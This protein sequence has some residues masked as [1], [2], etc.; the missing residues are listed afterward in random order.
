MTS[1]I[2]LGFSISAK[3]LLNEYSQKRGCKPYYS[4]SQK[5]YGFV[6]SVYIEG[7]LFEGAACS[8]KKV[9]EQYAAAEALKILAPKSYD[10]IIL[11]SRVT[12]QKRAGDEVDPFDPFE[13]GVQLLD[14]GTL[15]GK[16]TEGVP[17]TNRASTPTNRTIDPGRR[18]KK[19][20]DEKVDQKGS[21]K[22]VDDVDQ[23]VNPERFWAPVVESAKEMNVPLH[24]STKHRDGLCTTTLRIGDKEYFATSINSYRE[25]EARAFDIAFNVLAR[26]RGNMAQSPNSNGGVKGTRDET[27]YPC[28]YYLDASEGALGNRNYDIIR[29]VEKM[30]DATEIHLFSLNSNPISLGIG[31]SKKFD[32]VKE[33]EMYIAYQASNRVRDGYSICIVTRSPLLKLLPQIDNRITVLNL[34]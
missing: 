34:N 30:D 14:Q 32:S 29:N 1:N 13:K 10:R 20:G 33:I 27:L 7:M 23:E 25:S 5:E 6:G 18:S 9:A 8:E 16:R 24:W 2:A 26:M 12:A 3:S 17:T 22:V 11:R 31:T 4:V 21:G 28:I 19:V 15:E